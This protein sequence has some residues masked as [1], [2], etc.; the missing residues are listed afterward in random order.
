MTQTKD[1]T[2]ANEGGGVG[3]LE[4]EVPNE[5]V[6]SSSISQILPASQVCKDKEAKNVITN[7][8][9]LDTMLS[10]SPWSTR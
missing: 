2:F 8:L 7:I 10:G 9:L 5:V 6:S 4:F 3:G 1:L